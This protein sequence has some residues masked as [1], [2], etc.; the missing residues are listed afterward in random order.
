MTEGQRDRWH[1]IV[2]LMIVMIP[3]TILR[4]LKSCGPG[5]YGIDASYYVQ[6]ARHVMRGEG[7][8]NYTSLYHSG[9]HLPARSLMHPAWLLALGY[10]ARFMGLER[11]ANELPRLFY[12]IDL[13]LLYALARVVALRMG[14]LRF[15]PSRFLPDVAHCVTLL[16]GLSAAFYGSTTNPYREGLAFAAAFAALLLFERFVST[17]SMYAVVGSAAFAAIAYLS[18]VQM[19]AA[20]AAAVALLAFD[21]IRDRRSRKAALVYVVVVIAVV[22]PWFVQLGFVPR[23]ERFAWRPLVQE[24]LPVM[25]EEDVHGIS[26]ARI[27]DWIRGGFVQF[28]VGSDYSYVHV[29]GIAALLVP[30]A[31]LVWLVALRKRRGMQFNRDH[32]TVY[33]TL[34]AGLMLFVSLFVYRS[35]Y[36]PY[37][38]GWRHGLTLIFLIIVAVPY[39]VRQGSVLR[40]ITLAVLIVSMATG[41][42][43]I[44]GFI[45][46][47]NFAYSSGERQLIDWLAMSPRRPMILTTNAQALSVASD[48]YMHNTFCDSTPEATR[49]F[50][51][52]FPIDYVIVYEQETRCPYLQGLGRELHLLRAFGDPGGRIFVLS[53]QR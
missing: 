35:T 48:V 26:R 53:P 32:L 47:P 36:L 49:A 45:E 3:L 30:V 6:L 44:A 15:S 41:A 13:V 20:G 9:L 33:V 21:G 24:T 16:F 42:R 39:L 17:S 25:Q 28:Q 23:L 31:A 52:L 10:A 11:A 1:S 5:P 4:Y 51:K 14:A 2:W 37:M 19:A 7:L 29:F 46:A 8:M 50:L 43:A 38:F 27:A 34:A 18:R 22:T 12:L 40:V